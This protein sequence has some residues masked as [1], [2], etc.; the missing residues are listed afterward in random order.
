[1]TTVPKER[2]ANMEAAKLSFLRFVLFV[3]ALGHLIVGLSFWFFPELAIDE[4]LA[5]GPVSGWTT[6]LGSYDLSVAFA[7][8]LALRNPLANTG[9][10][11]FVGVLLILHALTH[12]Y[13]TVIGDSPPRFWF[14]I[15]YLLTGGIVLLWFGINPPV[16]RDDATYGSNE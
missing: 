10:I 16:P 15:A 11:K 8:F 9:I 1:M 6:I 7:L 12:A 5:W 3:A 4:I 2:L 13:Y 14:V